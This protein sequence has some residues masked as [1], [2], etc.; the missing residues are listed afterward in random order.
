MKKCPFCAEEIQDEAKICR[1]CGLD[2]NTGQP[3]KSI[4][5]ES[6]KDL[7]KKLKISDGVR[8]GFGMF[9]VLPLIII[10]VVIAVF[11]LLGNIG[12]LSSRFS[13]KQQ[14][15][16]ELKIAAMSDIN[17]KLSVA[18]LLFEM[19]MGYYPDKLS[20][21]IANSGLSDKWR[22]PYIE[23]IPIDPWGRDYIYERLNQ[24]NRNY[25]LCSK[26]P[27]KAKLDDDICKEQ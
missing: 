25:R 11:I 22:G 18:L 24:K 16:E 4:L 26:G 1:F 5:S 7:S 21:L 2:L 13:E 23:K 15:Q 3:V 6:S 10:G 27:S 14:K 8:I 12:F 19:D 17:A 20:D 9:I